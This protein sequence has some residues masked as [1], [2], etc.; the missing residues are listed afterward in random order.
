[1]QW[2]CSPQPVLETEYR[3]ASGTP[4]IQTPGTC[5]SW[6]PRD[7]RETT[8]LV[9]VVTIGL[10]AEDLSACRADTLRFAGRPHLYG[11]GPGKTGT[12][13]LAS[14]FTGIP[15]SHEPEA[16]SVI[17]AI[18]GY[19]SGRIDWRDLR[20]FV[21][22]RDRRLGLAIDVSNLNIFLIDFLLQMAPGAV[23]VLTVRDPYSWLD[24]ILNHYLSRPP[25]AEWRDL[26]GHRFAHGRLTHPP[27]ERVLFENGLFP[28]AGYLSY[29]RAHIEKAF[30]TVP[31]ERLLVVRTDRIAD[32]AERI[33]LFAGFP[34]TVVDRSRI[35][36]Y[37]NLH[38][39]PILQRI[40]RRHL[41]EQVRRHCEPF[42]SRLF[43]E[44][45]F[46]EDAGF[47]IPETIDP[48]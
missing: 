5:V 37:R 42:A 43:P 10:R 25:I 26:A 31:P 3:H 35:H 24:S 39:Q 28:L 9:Y 45:E 17:E 47:V 30:A 7:K 12:N 13:V 44:I 11:I 34:A 32:E 15:A 6:I 8:T 22:E 23:F 20:D 29:W 40:P 48:P 33:A 27:E 38:K 4:A 46:P 2:N 36:E 41:V 19:E 16:A 18:L 14:M 1:L 21:A